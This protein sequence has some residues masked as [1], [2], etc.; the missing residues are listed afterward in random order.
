ML[1]C[2]LE[3]LRLPVEVVRKR[4]S[5]FMVETEVMS[6]L[7]GDQ[8][9]WVEAEAEGAYLKYFKGQDPERKE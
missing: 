3:K 6:T 1:V 5:E 2:R 4:E 7:Y 9:V 8:H